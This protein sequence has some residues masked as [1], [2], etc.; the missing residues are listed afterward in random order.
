MDELEKLE[1]IVE[2]INNL[3]AKLPKDYP[4]EIVDDEGNEAWLHLQSLKFEPEE[5]LIRGWCEATN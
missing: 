4:I 3:L 5:H 2:D 1:D